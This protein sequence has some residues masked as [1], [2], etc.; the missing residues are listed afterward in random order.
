MKDITDIVNNVCTYCCYVM[1]YNYIRVVGYCLY[2]T[3]LL[4][5][6]YCMSRTNQSSSSH[7]CLFDINNDLWKK[8][9]MH[10]TTNTIKRIE[11]PDS[12]DKVY[13]EFLKHISDECDQ[14]LD[15]HATGKIV[16]K[17][18]RPYKPY[19]DKELTGAWK[20]LSEQYK[21]YKKSKE[22]K[23][24]DTDPRNNFKC[25]QRWFDK[26]LNANK[27]RHNKQMLEKIEQLKTSNHKDF[28]E[29]L[30]SLG[31]RKNKQIPNA[32][33]INGVVTMD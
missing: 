4:R 9:V 33:K 8:V 19:W 25:K 2:G 15:Y 12:L 3:L 29:H 27:R 17:K 31:P 5:P 14:H 1:G 7:R 21:L 23:N 6:C 13:S 20:E 24:N 18:C 32:V 11:D 26:L 10:L 22:K 28:W 16:R 30:N